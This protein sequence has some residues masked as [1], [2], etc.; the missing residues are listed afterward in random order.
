MTGV[1]KLL[2]LVWVGNWGDGE[3]SAEIMEFL[4]NPVRAAG[5]RARIYGVRYPEDALRTLRAARID[6]A[7]WIA[8]FKVPAAFAEARATVHVPRRFYRDELPGIP[9]I[10]VFEALACGIPLVTAPWEDEEGLFTPGRDFLVA[11]NADEMGRHLRCLLQDSSLARELIE[12]GRR[13]LLSRH[14]CGHRVE[15]LLAIGRQVGC[16]PLPPMN[17]SVAA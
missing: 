10:R 4:V 9:T 3:R 2:D 8:N 13:T 14:T 5:L 12:H 1:A 15:E 6:Y 17:E 16:T 7:G 11:R